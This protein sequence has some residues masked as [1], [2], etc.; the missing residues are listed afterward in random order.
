MPFLEK[1]KIWYFF[2]IFRNNRTWLKCQYSFSIWDD[3]Y[4]YNYD[5]FILPEII[6]NRCGKTMDLWV[7]QPLILGSFLLLKILTSGIWRASIPRGYQLGKEPLKTCE[8]TE[9]QKQ[10]ELSELFKLRTLIVGH[11]WHMDFFFDRLL[12]WSL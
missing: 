6:A 4:I 12:N 2:C 3:I 9:L 1:K 5:S 11:H 8:K 7:V 10:Q